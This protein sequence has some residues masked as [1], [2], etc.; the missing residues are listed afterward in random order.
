MSYNQRTEK[1]YGRLDQLA[2]LTEQPGII[3][4]TYGH[5]PFKQASL[6]VKQWMETAGL[7]T[8]I[9][10]IGNVRGRLN[11]TQAHAKTLVIASHIDTVIDAGKFDGPLGIVMAIDLVEN[12]VVNK[13]D[14][15]YTIEVVA[16]CDEEG[17]RFHTTYLGSK[18]LAGTFNEPLLEK[19]DNNGIALKE[20]IEQLNGDVA[21]LSNDRL[22]DALIGYFEIHIEQGPVL[23]QLGV[24][25]GVVTAIAGQKRIELVFTGVAGHAGTVPMNMRHDALCC[26]ADCISSIEQFALDHTATIVATVGTLVIKNSASNVI[27]SS[28]TC[29]LDLRSADNVRLTFAYNALQNIVANICED[30]KINLE[31]KVVQETSPIFC[32]AN[33]NTLLID[34]IKQAGH[35][36]IELASGAGHDAVAMSSVCPVAML[37][38]RCFEGISH[39]PLE[40]VESKDLAASLEVAERFFY[41]LADKYK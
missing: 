19:K 21:Q 12:L 41:N 34:S 16:F 20:V 26:A 8:R 22:H 17:V 23:W 36:S 2:L 27:P 14:L 28:V 7:Q 18:V 6:L 11:S 9:D 3:K 32:D 24:P 29:S 30:R 33:L 37:F 10:N 38:V 39:N 25:A 5:E 35:N 1:I 4:R 13:I 15:P 40:N 31:W